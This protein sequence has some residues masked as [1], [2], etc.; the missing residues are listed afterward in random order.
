ML[1]RFPSPRPSH[2]I[3]VGS[4]RELNANMDNLVTGFCHW[5]YLCWRNDLNGFGFRF[6]EFQRVGMSRGGEKMV[7][8][9]KHLFLSCFLSSFFI[10]SFSFPLFSNSY[11]FFF[12][13]SSPLRF[14][15]MA[16]S[17]PFILLDSM[18]FFHFV[19]KVSPT[20]FFF[21]W[22]PLQDNP[23]TRWLPGHYLYS[24]CVCCTIFIP[25][26]NSLFCSSPSSFLPY[27]NG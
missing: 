14:L 12:L 26:Q 5:S 21:L 4:R 2:S 24:E 20:I 19:L 22:A 7:Y 6:T 16:T 15:F 10:T 13:L 23:L 1:A 18:G 25:R 17:L 3:G 8:R 11:L 9:C 27:L